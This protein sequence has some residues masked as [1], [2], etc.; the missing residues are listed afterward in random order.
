MM[1]A[2]HADRDG[3]CN[4]SGCPQDRDDVAIALCKEAGGSPWAM[5]SSHSGDVAD[6]KDGN[7]N[8]THFE[9][10][11]WTGAADTARAVLSVKGDGDG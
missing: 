3:E 11:D 2:C 10:R 8:P 7:G 5:V 9:W 4:W 1:E 6:S